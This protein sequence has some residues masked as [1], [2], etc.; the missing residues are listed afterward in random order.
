MIKITW[1]AVFQFQHCFDT[2]S[3]NCFGGR[4]L[5][6]IRFQS[7]PLHV[8][9]TH[10]RVQSGGG[11]RGNKGSLN[12]QRNVWAT[13]FA[14]AC[15]HDH[16]EDNHPACEKRA[17]KDNDDLCVPKMPKRHWRHPPLLSKCNNLRH[18]IAEYPHPPPSL[19]VRSNWG[20]FTRRRLMGH[21]NPWEVR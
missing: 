6:D 12:T 17:P 4:F 18:R 10:G 5:G 9:R 21:L 11:P 19:A 3:A 7:R 2:V 20:S 13:Q 14:G 8:R 15:N 16:N 1:T